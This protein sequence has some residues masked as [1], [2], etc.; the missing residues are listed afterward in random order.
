MRNDLG[1]LIFCFGIFVGAILIFVAL[2]NVWIIPRYLDAK[3]LCEQSIPRDKQ[4]VM[5]FKAEQ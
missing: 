5:Y 3:D 2:S 4:C 1:G